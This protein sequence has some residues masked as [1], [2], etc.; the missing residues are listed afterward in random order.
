MI[1]SS[2]FWIRPYKKLSIANSYRSGLLLHLLFRKKWVH[3]AFWYFGCGNYRYF[4]ICSSCLSCGFF[5]GKCSGSFSCFCSRRSIT[6][7]QGMPNVQFGS[8]SVLSTKSFMLCVLA[9]NFINV[10][11]QKKRLIFRDANPAGSISFLKCC[12]VCLK[13]LL[14]LVCQL[15]YYDTGDRMDFV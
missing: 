3:V 4:L 12:F 9:Q 15:L 11:I 8:Y 2:I 6:L 13:V 1:P 7:F 5:C 10:L 14:I